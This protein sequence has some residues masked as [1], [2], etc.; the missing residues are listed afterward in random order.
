VTPRKPPAVSLLRRFRR[1]E[2]AASAVEFALIAPLMLF[3]LLGTFE[4]T[5]A[6]SVNRKVEEMAATVSRFV[7]RTDGVTKADLASFVT[8]SS[9]VM[10]PN[11]VDK[12][13]LKVV[14]RRVDKKDETSAR[15]MWSYDWNK[16]A[17]G[18]TPT[19]ADIALVANTV[20][21]TD[22]TYTH[23]VTFTAMLSSLNLS[24]FHLTAS[25]DF[26]PDNLSTIEYKG[27]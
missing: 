22:I 27:S 16:D 25:R 23:K 12:T 5:R 24:E 6:F 9:A 18:N 20:I 17:V 8:A 19:D 13:V 26:V 11:A 3:M 1:G 15:V 7:T 4:I 14:V 10:F 2:E 21:R